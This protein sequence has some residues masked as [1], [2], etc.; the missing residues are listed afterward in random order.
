MTQRET[1]S[2]ATIIAAMLSG[3]PASTGTDPD[4][5]IRA[6]LLAIDGIA[7]DAIARAARLFISGQVKD[8]NR[9]F[10][11]SCASFAEQC[12]YQQAAI[13]AERRPRIEAR[14]QRD[15]TPRVDPR[16]LRMLNAALKGDYRARKRLSQMYPHLNIEIGEE[17]EAKQ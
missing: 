7:P 6:Y 4:M 3:F 5:Q 12:R 9:E 2:P 11:P 17:S 10:A 14:P 1:S 8:H 13:E 15:D 16:K